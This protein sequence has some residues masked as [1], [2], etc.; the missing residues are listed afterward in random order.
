MLAGCQSVALTES[1]VAANAGVEQ[2][3]M[4]TTY[5]TFA[6]SIP[7]LRQ[8]T[9]KTLAAMGIDVRED[10]ASETGW[11]IA[12]EAGGRAINVGLERITRRTT[13]MKVE[14]DGDL[15]LLRDSATGTEII[16]Q[17]TEALE[18]LAVRG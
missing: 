16:L 6:T 18:L 4:G 14:V 10:A 12:G 1:G 8:A 13:R 2:S 7:T 9:L 11:A 5:K 17:T 15:P 3:L